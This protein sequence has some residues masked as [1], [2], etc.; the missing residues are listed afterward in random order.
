[1]I[2]SLANEATDSEIKAMTS[3][4]L[5][6]ILRKDVADAVCPQVLRDKDAPTRKATIIAI[7]KLAEQRECPL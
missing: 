1:M 3:S 6:L 4:N 5:P 2:R 7:G